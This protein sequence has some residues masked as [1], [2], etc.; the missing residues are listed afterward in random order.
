MLGFVK[1]FHEFNQRLVI[2]EVKPE[3]FMTPLEQIEWRSLPRNP[4]CPLVIHCE[5]G[6]FC[7]KLPAMIAEGNDLEWTVGKVMNWTG[8][9]ATRG[10]HHYRNYRVLW[11]QEAAI[12]SQERQRI[13]AEILNNLHESPVFLPREDGHDIHDQ[14]PFIEDFGIAMKRA[15]RLVPF[16]KKG[17]GKLEIRKVSEGQWVLFHSRWTPLGFESFEE[18]AAF[19]QRYIRK[20]AA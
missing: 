7:W 15:E 16:L 2:Y 17:K 8:T 18:A 9:L 14:T 12:Y 1:D 5:S 11:P 3:S 4:E 19:A 6:V 10:V 20:G 13:I